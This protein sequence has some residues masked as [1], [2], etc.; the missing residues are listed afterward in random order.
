MMLVERFRFSKTQNID[1]SR[2]E[3]EDFYFSYKDS[4]P[5]T[6]SLYSYSCFEFEVGSGGGV[7]EKNKLLAESVLKKILDGI[8]KKYQTI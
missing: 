5:L 7:V 2:K 8:L 3:V 1:V 6:P 4:L